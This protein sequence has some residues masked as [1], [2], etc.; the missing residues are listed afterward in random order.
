MDRGIGVYVRR[1][2]IF[3]GIIALLL[4]ALVLS[5]H[6][7]T[8]GTIDGIVVGRE[9]RRAVEGAVVSIERSNS[10]ATTNKG[11]H[12]RL[13]GV[14]LGAATIVVKAQGFLDMSVPGVQ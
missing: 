9:S 8:L 7:Q 12:F 10:S 1:Q 5:A 4:Q 2:V 3:V 11:G 6:A 13:T 14:P